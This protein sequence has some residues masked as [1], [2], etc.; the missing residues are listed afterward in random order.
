MGVCNSGNAWNMEVFRGDRGIM[1]IN[2]KKFFQKIWELII[3]IFH[4]KK[5][6]E[7]TI[8]NTSVATETVTSVTKYYLHPDFHYPECGIVFS[9]FFAKCALINR[10]EYTTQDFKDFIDEVAR[11]NLA[12]C[13][14]SFLY[15]VW[16]P[17]SAT[18]Q[19]V[20]FPHP[21]RDG[22]F[23]LEEINQE[24]LNQLIDRV[25]YVV[26]R[27][28][29]Y[30]LIQ[31]DECQLHHNHFEQWH[32]LCDQNNHGWFGK[33]TYADKYGWTKWV[34]LSDPNFG[35]EE[36]RRKYEATGEYIR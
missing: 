25:G 1:S 28:I 29:T 22:K 23:V 30:R 4:R 12:N 5:Q 36:E 11:Y 9:P 14:R 16:I 15:G 24:W 17:G 19:V 2:F 27:G 35:T 7:T 8:V 34:H 20:H 10:S 13:M 3:S 33:E 31:D 32:W 18:S 26:D 21:K 6:Q